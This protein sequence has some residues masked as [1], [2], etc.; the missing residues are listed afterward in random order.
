MIIV[1]HYY[2]KDKKNT[3]LQKEKVILDLKS[4]LK[5][6]QCDVTQ[7]DKI[8]EIEIQVYHSKV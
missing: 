8:D 6:E 5:H 3:S 1:T 7:F 2:C 4:Y